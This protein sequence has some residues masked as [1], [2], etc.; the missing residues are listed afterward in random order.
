MVKRLFEKKKKRIQI[1]NQNIIQERMREQV[2]DGG[3]GEE[4]MDNF[5]DEGT[6]N[7]KKFDL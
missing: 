4:L 6:I 5:I 3:G 1:K 2:A 7:V